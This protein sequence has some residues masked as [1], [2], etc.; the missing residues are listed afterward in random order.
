MSKKLTD[1][2]MKGL[3]SPS[4]GNRIEYDSEVKGFGG[5]VTANGAKAFVLTY[6]TRAGVQHRYTIGTFPEWKTLSARKEAARLKREVQAGADP[7]KELREERD[8]PTMSD[9][10]A[11]YLDEHAPKKRSAEDDERMFR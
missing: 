2:I 1:A 10:A 9:L 8:A 3:K 7:V 5:R 4:K 11:R 6:R